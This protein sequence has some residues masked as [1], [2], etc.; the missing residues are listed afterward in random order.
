MNTYKTTDLKDAQA[1]QTLIHKGELSFGVVL[2]FCTGFLVKKVGKFFAAMVGVA[3]L[4]MQY[5]S[6]KG[7]VTVNWN[8]MEH[9]YNRQLGIGKDGK[10]ATSALHSKWDDFVGFLT[11]NI[12][13]KSTFLL[14]LYGGIHYG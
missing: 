1:S 8:R 12:Q 4:F 13:F 3:F 10:G 5:L 9:Q 6:S 11:S 2:G 7:Y 14:G